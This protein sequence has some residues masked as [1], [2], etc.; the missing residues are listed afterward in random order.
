MLQLFA[1][2]VQA[3]KNIEFLRK[4]ELEILVT[5]NTDQAEIV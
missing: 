3:R 1:K 4:A 5:S 2:S